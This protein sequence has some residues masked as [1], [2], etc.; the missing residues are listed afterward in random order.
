M[1]LTNPC[2][3]QW[4]D[5]QPSVSGRYCDSC[6][7]HIVDLTNKSDA[8]LIQFFKKKNDNVC[9]R[10][11]ANQLNRELVLPRPK[12]SWHWLLPLAIGAVAI[13]PARAS[14]LR[15]IANQED[16]SAILPRAAA[17]NAV[18][19]PL[20][21][22]TIKGS[23]VSDQ[24]GKPLAGVK[25]KQKGFQNVLA[26]TDSTGKF[27]IALPT[28]NLS[29]TFTF[30]LNGYGTAESPLNHGQTVRLTAEVRVMLGGVTAI[31]TDRQPLYVVYSG[32]KSCTIEASRMSE[33]SP[34]WIE[35]LEILKNP[36]ATAIYGSKA[37]YGVVLIEIK[38]AFAKKIK[39]SKKK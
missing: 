13:S 19:A 32:K 17:Q 7:K 15:P 5:M 10:L 8:E 31:S 18:I 24:T 23:V 29:S 26:L 11:M 1:I 28:E 25:I 12:T 39:F 33:I 34:D 21:A 9:G 27:E 4:D 35:K 36:E 16:G 3:Q 14:E 22:D 6:E 38:K 30:E 37:A 2:T 20:P